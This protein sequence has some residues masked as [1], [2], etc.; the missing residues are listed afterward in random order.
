M[1][2]QRVDA[3][4]SEMEKVAEVEVCRLQRGCMAKW[5]SWVVG[6]DG[7]WCGHKEGGTGGARVQGRI[8]RSQGER[9]TPLGYKS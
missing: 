7:A 3:G 5:R 9:S 8:K 2:Q 4:I 1:G 6:C